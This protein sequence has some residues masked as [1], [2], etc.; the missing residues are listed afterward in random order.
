MGN[1][2]GTLAYAP[3]T[4]LPAGRYVVSFDLY[5]DSANTGDWEVVSNLPNKAQ[6]VATGLITNS[7]KSRLTT[8]F[9]VRKASDTEVRV[10]Y[11]GHGTLFVDIICVQRLD[12]SQAAPGAC[13]AP[14]AAPMLAST[15]GNWNPLHPHSDALTAPIA[16]CRM[17]PAI[18]S[19]RSPLLELS[20]AIKSYRS[21]RP[22]AH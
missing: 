5:A 19:G 4:G 1:G 12:P 17:A 6:V 16:S 18:M 9:E 21:K 22:R 3:L 8:N 7:G 10:N 15:E 14:G 11:S 13:H 20:L 2:D